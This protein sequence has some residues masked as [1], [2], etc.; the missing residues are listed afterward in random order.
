MSELEDVFALFLHIPTPLRLSTSTKMDHWLSLVAMTAYGKSS[1]CYLTAFFVF[2]RIWDTGSGQ[3]LKTLI[4]QDNPPVSFVRFSPN[5]RFI[6]ASNLDSTIKLWDYRKGHCRK[7]YRGHINEKYCIFA[8]FSIT[9]GKVR[10][11]TSNLKP[12][13][14]V[15]CLRFGG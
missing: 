8:N 14:V 11:D 4:D 10:H 15:R 13:L 1:H 12:F 3:C 7:V 9:G 5:G 2:S 6:L